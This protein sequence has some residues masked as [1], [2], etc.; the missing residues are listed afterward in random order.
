MIFL[1]SSHTARG[2]SIREKRGHVLVIPGRAPAQSTA[3]SSEE[4]KREIHRIN[5]LAAGVLPFGKVHFS[6]QMN[7]V[8]PSGAT[9][10]KNI[11]ASVRFAF[12]QKNII[13]R[14]D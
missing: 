3:A 10:G 4:T 5:S 6:G 13:P 9:A 2:G 14:G 8:L 1:T 7:A 11:H 12:S